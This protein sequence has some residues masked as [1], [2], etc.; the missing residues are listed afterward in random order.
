[1][2]Y[3]KYALV[4][5]FIL[6][7]LGMSCRDESLYPLPYDD[8]VTGAY[9][10]MY[11]ITSNV[12]D[13]N[14][15]NNSA[16]E[17]I[18]EAVDEQYGDNLENVEFYAS[19]RRGNSVTSEVLIKTIPGTDFA[20]VAEPT[21][22]EY[23]RSN[24]RITA[25]E[26]LAAL[27]AGASGTPP[28]TW[29]SGLT[30]ATYPFTPAIQAADQIIYR[31]VMVLK[32]G[33]KFTVLN[34]QGTN[35]G[36]NNNT[37]NITTGQFYSAPSTFT[38]TVRSFPAGAYTGAYALRQVAIWSPSHS[39][40]LHQIGYPSYLNEELFERDQTVT[41]ARPSG[42]LST[43][44][45]FTVKYKGQN[46]SMRINFEPT[47]LG[48]TGAGGTAAIANSL[49]NNYGF[50]MGTTNGNL[51]TVYVALQ[52]STVDCSSERELYWT[53]PTGGTFGNAPSA[54]NATA[55]NNLA[56]GLPQNLIPNRGAYR[57]DINGLTSGDIFSIS[58]DDDCDE[59]G[60]RNGYC[61]WTR[62]VYLTLR[63][64]P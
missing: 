15:L 39:V 40:E 6:M 61:T 22:S 44:R 46:V 16:F 47:T 57:T 51:G 29:T 58:V 31:W 23:K 13:L 25:N 1:M 49:I 37:P 20:A 34:P 32:D 64:L 62:R 35:P 26:T 59:Y 33:R 2:N 19:F 11:K 54:T 27:A 17:T 12:W 38:L 43:E 41:L 9:L 53:M 8:R 45:E 14:D 56:P 7:A 30:G 52:N 3:K 42:G 60:R 5:A 55:L 28:T 21:Y 48:L 18:Y 36:E 63:K 4:F 24:I 10:R 50:P